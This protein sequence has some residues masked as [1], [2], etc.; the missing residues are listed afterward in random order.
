MI[1]RSVRPSA[2]I[3]TN[4]A[5]TK[6]SAPMLIGNTVP[7]TNNKINAMIDTS[8]GV[9]CGP[10]IRARWPMGRVTVD[11]ERAVAQYR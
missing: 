5:A 4:Q 6:P 3:P 8:S 7:T 11:G 9:M 2:Y 10:W 1:S